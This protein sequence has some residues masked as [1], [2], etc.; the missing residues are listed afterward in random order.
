LRQAI[1]CGSPRPSDALP[2]RSIPHSL[3]RT[4]SPAARPAHG[5]AERD[6]RTFALTTILFALVAAAACLIP[7]NRATRV[8]P[9]AVLRGE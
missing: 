4:S 1:R 8:N 3:S 9:V 5:I 7:A 6:P 2:P